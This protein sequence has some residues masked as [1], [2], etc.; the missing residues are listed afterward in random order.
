[1]IPLTIKCLVEIMQIILLCSVLFLFFINQHNKA[2]FINYISAF[3][4]VQPGV[5]SGM[6][7]FELAFLLVLFGVQA[8]RRHRHL[9]VSTFSSSSTFS[10]WSMAAPRAV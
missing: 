5:A 10:S 6:S 9:L 4:T 7:M 1:M 3:S 8:A 2:Q